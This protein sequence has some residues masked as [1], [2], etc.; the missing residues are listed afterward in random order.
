MVI[1]ENDVPYVVE[2]NPRFQGTLECVER[3][4][5]IN[6]VDAHI[7]ACTKDVLPTLSKRRPQTC[8]VRLILYARQRSVIPNLD[9]LE[10]V[11]DIPLSGVVVEEG[12]PL[13]SIVV[14]G[15]TRSV[16]LKK[17]KTLAKHVYGMIEPKIQ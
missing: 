17:G 9:S 11:R 4:L 13:C 6:L 8:C 1:S 14:G 3:V 12:E 2:V 10:E 7:K 5:G 15:K 16:A